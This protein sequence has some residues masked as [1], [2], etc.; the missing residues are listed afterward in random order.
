VYESRIDREL[1]RRILANPKSLFI[2]S[3]W[4]DVTSE[5][6][7][8][9]LSARR[10]RFL[11]F[12]DM[13]NPAKRRNPLKSIARSMFLRFAFRNA[14]AVLAAGKPAMDAIEALGCPKEKLVNFPFFIDLDAFPYRVADKGS[15]IVFGTCTRLAPGKGIELAISALAQ[16]SDSQERRFKY[17]VAGDGPQKQAL[18]ELTEKLGMSDRV[19]FVGWLEPNAVPSF[20]SRLHFL[21]HPSDFESY[22][23]TIL[24]GM[25]SGCVIIASDQIGAV[26]DRIVHGTSGI[27][28]RC[29]MEDLRLA[30]ETA[31]SMNEET[32]NAMAWQARLIA[33]EWPTMRAV[34]I[35]KELL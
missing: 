34:G 33:E 16:L 17:L 8:S 35:L 31:I 11:V 27:V 1:I 22:G 5:I 26:L 10:R 21:L 15:E 18:E 29:S 12:N 4:H 6:C 25:A 19:H 30:I 28:H 23:V 9:L 24:E 14:F 32:R 2:T 13:P 3:C 7:I 20:Y